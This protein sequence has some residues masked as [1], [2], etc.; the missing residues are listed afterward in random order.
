[1]GVLCVVRVNDEFFLKWKVLVGLW[2]QQLQQ[3]TFR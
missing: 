3:L 2:K 1:V